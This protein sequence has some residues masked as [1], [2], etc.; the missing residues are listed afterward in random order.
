MSERAA[1]NKHFTLIRELAAADVLT[2]GNASCGTASIFLCLNYLDTQNLAY[3]WWAMGLLPLAL[4]CD[5]LDGI[6]ARKRRHSVYGAD[7]DSLADIVS[8]GVAPATLAYTLGMRGGW[9]AILLIYFV[10]CGISRLARYNVTMD[11]LA[12]PESGKVKYYE[13]TPIPASILLVAVLAIAVGVGAV[14]PE[15]WW[16]HVKLGM[17]LHPLT[18]LFGL[19]GTAMASATLRVPKP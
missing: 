16:G 10:A 1:K 14:G 11:S 7:M 13:G 3:V 12:D 5:A 15:L 8:F 2:I 19:S 17:T 18:V 9:D 4:V 6:V